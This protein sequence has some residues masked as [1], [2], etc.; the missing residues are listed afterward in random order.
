MRACAPSPRQTPQPWRL[1]RQS[2]TRRRR[3]A[4]GGGGHAFA[5]VQLD[6]HFQMGAQFV[7]QVV[8]ETAAA[9]ECGETLEK[10][11]E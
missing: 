9:E 10:R 8:F 7:V 6:G 11:A 5:Q 2:D 3:A 1:P 4:G